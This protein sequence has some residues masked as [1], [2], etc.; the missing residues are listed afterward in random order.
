MFQIHLEFGFSVLQWWGF[1]V[2]QWAGF[3]TLEQS[4]CLLSC[5]M[6]NI[7]EKVYILGI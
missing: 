3:Q 4:S 5:S 2:Q 6:A 1:S 7:A